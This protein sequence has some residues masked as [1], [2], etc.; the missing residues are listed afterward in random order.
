MPSAFATAVP[1][2]G[3]PTEGEGSSLLVFAVVVIGTTLTLFA[4]GLVQAATVRA[5][6]EIDAG[7]PI[8]PLRAYRLAGERLWRWL[9]APP[10]EGAQNT[11]GKQETKKEKTT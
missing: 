9:L 7:R 8:D 1:F 3:V 10:D 2:A 4:L 11:E 5:L 6:V